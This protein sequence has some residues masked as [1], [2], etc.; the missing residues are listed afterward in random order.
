MGGRGSLGPWQ[1]SRIGRGKSYL[2]S[3]LP[4]FFG[5][6]TPLLLTP[7][8]MIQGA[9]CVSG[10]FSLVLRVFHHLQSRVP[11]L[12]TSFHEAQ[13]R[14][15]AH[16]PPPPCACEMRRAVPNNQSKSK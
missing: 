5:I 11:K 15:G 13:I 1:G 8:L 6:P 7:T 10:K 12:R 16:N 9:G 14:L 3:K 2:L 4:F